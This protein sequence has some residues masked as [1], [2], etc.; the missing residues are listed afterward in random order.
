MKIKRAVAIGKEYE[1]RTVGDCI[2]HINF[3]SLNMFDYNKLGDELV[4]LDMDLEHIA[5]KYDTTVE[6]VENWTIKE[7]LHYEG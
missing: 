2:S 4:A 6:E 3:H 5:R 7:F 1:K